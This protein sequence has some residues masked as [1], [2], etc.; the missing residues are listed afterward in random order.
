MG[1]GVGGRSK[2]EGIYV[3]IQVIHFIAQQKLTQH[4]KA[5]ILRLKK[6]EEI[7]LNKCPMSISDLISNLPG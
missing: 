2:R 4:C 6:K 3:Y 7:L 1:V 5:I